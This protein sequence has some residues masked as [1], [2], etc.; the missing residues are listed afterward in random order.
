MHARMV[1]ILQGISVMPPIMVIAM[2]TGPMAIIAINPIITIDTRLIG[3][4]DIGPGVI[5][6]GAITGV[7]KEGIRTGVKIM[8]DVIMAAARRAGG[9]CRGVA[10]APEPA[11]FPAEA[12][13]EPVVFP[14]EAVLVEVELAADD[15]DYICGSCNAEIYH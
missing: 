2:D 11:V 7:A 15:A 4:T 10:A 5:I 1:I 8:A 14:A 3:P 12:V 9:D 6:G 13:L